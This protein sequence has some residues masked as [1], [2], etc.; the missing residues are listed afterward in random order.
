MT[1]NFGLR[2]LDLR[3][4]GAASAWL[5]VLCVLLVGNASAQVSPGLYDYPRPSLDWYTIETEHFSIL[6]HANEDNQGNSRSAQV[7][8][9][10]AEEIY[11]PIT[12]L[13]DHEPDTKVSIILKDYEDYSNGA[14]YFFDN[15]IE[16]WSPSLDSPLRGE[17]NWLRNV[18]THEFTHIIQVQTAMKANRRMPFLYLQVLDYEDVRR[19][20]VL[21]GYPNVIVTYPIP[22]LNNPAWLAEGSAQYQRTWLDYDRWDA[23][24]DML[25]RTRV[26]AGKELSLVEMGGFYSK[27]SL[28]R[29]GVYNHGFSFTQYLAN[30]YG[31]DALRDISQSFS[32]WRNWNQERALEDALGVPADEVYNGWMGTMRT[33]YEARTAD[34]QAHKVEG[35]LVEPEGF[36]NFYPQ[37]SP[38]GNRLAYVSNRG[39]DYNRMSLYVRD[40]DSDE[41]AVYEIDGLQEAM[42]THTCA[43]GHKVKSGVGGAIS[44]RP[45]GQAIVY[46][47]TKDT[48]EGFLFSDLYVFDLETEKEE[49]LTKRQRA[50][51]PAY[52]P[53]GKR[54]V[55]VNHGDGS[56]NLSLLNIETEAVTRI[57]QFEDGSQV[58]DPVWHPG[59]EW[60]Y[61]AY[62]DPEGHGRDL[63]RVRSDGSDLTAVY[64]TDADERNPA[65]DPEGEM[66]YFAS[67]VSG[68]FNLYRMPV[69]SSTVTPERLTNVLGGAF[70]PDVR[71]DGAM[72]FA[73]YQWDGYKIAM[74]EEAVPV[75]EQARVASYSPP[76]VM[77]NQA[78]QRAIASAD[79]EH[80]NGFDD[81]DLRPLEEEAI[82][83]V[84]TEGSFP[85]TV[86]RGSDNE[87]AL[88]PLAVEKYGAQFTS[89]SF[90]PVLRLD[91]YVSRERSRIDV[92]LPDRTRGETL[93]RN[94][95]IGTYFSSREI[96]EGLSLFGGLLVGPA[97][98]DASSL[99]DFFSPSR[100]LKLER[101]AF[102]QFEYKKGFGII[103]QRWS[104]QITLEL[105]NIRRRVDNGLSIEEFPCTACFP[106]TTLADISYALWEVD[107]Y[108]RS[109]V[110]RSLLLEAGYRYS[111]YKVITDQFFSKESQVDIPESSS[112][113][114]IGR[115]FTAKAYFEAFHPY[116]DSD[117]VPRGLKLD[118]GYEY[119][120][121]RLLN[122]FNIEDGVLVPEYE[123]EQNHEVQFDAR[124]GLQ[125]P[126][127]PLGGSHG[128]GFRF[129][130]SS[131]LGEEVD[132]F[133]NNYVGGLVGARGYPFYAL[134]GNETLW[135]QA[136][137][138]MPLFPD[139]RKQFLFTYIDKVYAR[140]YADA[141]MAWSGPWPGTEAIRKDVGAE[142]RLGLD[143]FYLLPTAV[144]LSGT[145]GLD[146]F[147]FQLD[148]GFLTPD[149]SN[150]VRYGKEL[151]WHFGVLFEF[152]L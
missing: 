14:A 41:L 127:E 75:S 100:L 151:Q 134:G 81:R 8:A 120:L 130:A 27:S 74:L 80:L 13:Y 9:R 92:R 72:A 10:I 111:P 109:K 17:H 79:Q 50:T 103:P 37:F 125:L 31:E 123:E 126:G 87:P 145:Y 115:A 146:T 129:Q 11:E 15:K 85:L 70:M 33:E 48:R 124:L 49:Q 38:D 46:A 96:L 3:I 25:L 55:F 5:L 24:R 106:D 58:I 121:G 20:D 144:F 40:L 12:S 35:E 136:S 82:T 59:G 44:W 66:L 54:I 2:I 117:V 110:N 57:T 141:A 86:K 78:A 104:P 51:L 7:V 34:I 28:M 122:S 16:I 18:I 147:D 36:S 142:L 118:L 62:F 84:R 152:D 21:Y 88:E 150:T 90:Y 56:T 42:L 135:F 4:K 6:F 76:P 95:K 63:W 119:E 68:I 139:I 43:L 101:D 65:F 140:F 67:D 116:R 45:D 53:D 19:P 97:T 105:F 137:Y 114:F 99:T 98:Q 29:E 73:Q 102:L 22:V 39:E 64:A 148:E 69:E 60:I 108:V 112:R 138:N 143:S 23:H 91:Q 93:L 149:G 30:T 89:F 128:L 47:K 52:S 26:L 107:A 133:Y 83:A 131:I 132:D 77:E 113:Y 32:K 94:A 71:A 61:F 1:A